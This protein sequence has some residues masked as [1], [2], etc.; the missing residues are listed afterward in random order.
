MR[1]QVLIEFDSDTVTD[2]QA[3]RYGQT[4]LN[5]L[6][7]DPHGPEYNPFDSELDIRTDHQWVRVVRDN[8]I[9]EVLI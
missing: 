6:R 2:A 5:D 7:I 9:V 1:Y 8:M 3:V 4:L